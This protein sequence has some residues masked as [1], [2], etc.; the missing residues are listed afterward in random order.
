MLNMNERGIESVIHDLLRIVAELKEAEFSS[1]FDRTK[2]MIHDCERR[3]V[4][5]RQEII[6]S[7]N[8]DDN[9]EQ[10]T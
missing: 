10:G 2:V 3:L 4:R 9:E 6:E 5:L 7:I 1:S 8:G